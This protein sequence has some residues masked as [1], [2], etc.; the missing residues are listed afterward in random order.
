MAV[1]TT[2]AK[3]RLGRHVRPI[4]ERTGLKPI[5]VSK[6]VRTSKDTVDRLLSGANLPR[7]PTFLAIMTV[8]KATEEELAEGTVLWERANQDAVVVEHAAALS[9][10]YL[11]FRMDEGEASRERSL[12]QQIV[13]GL[14]QLGGYAEA[15]GDRA[16]VLMAGRGWMERAAAERRDR[17]GLLSREPTFRLHALIDEV[18]LH[19]VVGG[20][21]LMATQLAHLIEVAAQDNVTIQILPFDAGSYGLHFG[22]LTLLDYPEPDEPLSVYIEE[23]TG[24]KV[25]E[26]AQEADRLVAAWEDAARLALDPEQSMK[27]IEEVRTTR[28]A[29]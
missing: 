28:Y 15:L 18:A 17:Q 8:I 11:R 16:R 29:A 13:P 26:D 27:R 25:V 1:G 14:L 7:F 5:E 3:R 24:I 6:L 20:H 22:A 2:R 9:S 12:S 4:L 23:H 21:E 10:R 19:R